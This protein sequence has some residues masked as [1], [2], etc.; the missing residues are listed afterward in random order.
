MRFHNS[1]ATLDLV[2]LVVGGGQASVRHSV[3]FLTVRCILVNES[4]VPGKTAFGFERLFI[5]SFYS[6]LCFFRSFCNGSPAG[7]LGFNFYSLGLFLQ[8]KL[9]PDFKDCQISFLSLLIKGQN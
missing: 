9:L 4:C 5:N 2:Q 6:R 8:H 7:A 3:S 1:E